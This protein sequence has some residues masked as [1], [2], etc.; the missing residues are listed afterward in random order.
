MISSHDLNTQN[1]DH[2]CFEEQAF[3]EL[4]T[5]IASAYGPHAADK[6]P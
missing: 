4:T 6:R 1:K 5:R 3:R 2:L